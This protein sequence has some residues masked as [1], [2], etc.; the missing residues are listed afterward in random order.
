MRWRGHLFLQ[1][2]YESDIRREDFGFKSKNTPP[3]CKHMEAFEKEFIDMIQKHQI[4]ICKRYISEEVKRE[5]FQN[6]TVTKIFCLC[7][8][9]KRYP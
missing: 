2:K 1:E 6:K 3:K 9:N 7:I 5:H 8:D 4:S